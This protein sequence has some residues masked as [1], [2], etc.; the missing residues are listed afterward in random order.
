MQN[1]VDPISALEDAIF[2][3][4]KMC[5]SL[6]IS[7][8]DADRIR[9][10]IEDCLR[11]ARLTLQKREETDKYKHEAVEL[12]TFLEKTLTKLNKQKRLHLYLNAKE[13]EL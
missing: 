6:D 8:V 12:D 1:N 11:P 4:E 5:R 2:D 9:C 3:L 13:K 7:D 10:V